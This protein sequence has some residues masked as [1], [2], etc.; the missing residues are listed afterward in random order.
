MRVPAPTNY[1]RRDFGSYATEFLE[2]GTQLAT[3]IKS[4]VE[5]A[6]V[7]FPY[8]RGPLVLAAAL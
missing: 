7:I 1:H 5:L 8:V 2:K 3:A 6:E 4:G